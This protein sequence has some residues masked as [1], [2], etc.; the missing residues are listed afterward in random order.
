[1]DPE[2][3]FR[4]TL[5]QAYDQDIPMLQFRFR[6]ADELGFV[7]EEF[8]AAGLGF[9]C[10]PDPD[11]TGYAEHTEENPLLPVLIIVDLDDPYRAVHQAKKPSIIV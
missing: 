8:A 3:M 1:M 7:L 10:T 9:T 11:D 5:L 2:L 4:P 6:N